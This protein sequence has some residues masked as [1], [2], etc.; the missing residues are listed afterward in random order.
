MFKLQTVPVE[1]APENFGRHHETRRALVLCNVSCDQTH[2]LEYL[3]QFTVLLVAQSLNRAR[4]DDSLLVSQRR[5]DCVLCHRSFTRRSVGRHQHTLVVLDAFDRLLLERVERE[6][7][8]PCSRLRRLLRCHPAFRSQH[9]VDAAYLF[10]QVL[11]L[12]VLQFVVRLDLL[13]LL[14]HRFVW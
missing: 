3:P 14:L 13:G 6:L 7:I 11:Q 1:H 8:L 9:L 5:G 2:I 10:L 4:V 12:E